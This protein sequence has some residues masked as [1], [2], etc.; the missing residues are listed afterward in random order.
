MSKQRI[1]L[2]D[3]NIF[4]VETYKQKMSNRDLNNFL[5]SLVVFYELTAT[6]I[7]RTKR[8]AWEQILNRKLQNGLCVVPTFEDWRVSARIIGEMHT[9]KKYS[10]PKD[11]TKLQN[12]MLICHSA[13]AW[14][15]TDPK[16]RPPILIVTDN[17]ADF[18]KCLDGVHRHYDKEI[19]RNSLVK[20]AI[21][22]G[23][24]YFST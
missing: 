3:T 19:K 23:K 17:K 14:Y 15:R 11:A 8:Q 20:I 18:D 7:Y 10:V 24:D 21:V 22:T 16:S 9:R 12:D 13:F 6:P 1:R 5:F 4:G 2:F